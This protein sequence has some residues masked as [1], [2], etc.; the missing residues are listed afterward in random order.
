[1]LFRAALLVFGLLASAAHA[2][3]GAEALA[4]MCD[5]AA[6]GA[7]GGQSG[8]PAEVLLALTRTETGRRLNGALRPWPWTV[9]MEGEG[10]WFETEA[11]A[12]AFVRRRHAAGARSFDIGCFQ[13]NF[14]WHGE[15]FS[16]FEEMFDPA[17]GA[18]YAARFLADLK[19][20]GGGW[21]EAVGRYHS[22]TPQFANRYI[23]RWE[24]ILAGLDLVKLPDPLSPRLKAGPKGF[25]PPLFAASAGGAGAPP[26]GGVL[27]AA[28]AHAAPDRAR[29]NW[30]GGVA[31]SAL[32]AGGAPLLR[33][34]RPLFDA[35]PNPNAKAE[36]R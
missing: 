34:G 21:P 15:H 24:D 11:E 1:M 33:A 5:R 6:V 23:A 22:R 13:I 28:P 20:E 14:R 27:V 29:A 16:G 8:V 12:L 18:A 25:W 30:R 26:L 31:L 35:P 17:A 19:G 3:P 10:F 9:N 7:A 32:S 4:E 36:V 2:A